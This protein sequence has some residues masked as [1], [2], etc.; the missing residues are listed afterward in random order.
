MH[1]R[2]HP[3]RRASTKEEG[4]FLGNLLRRSFDYNAEV[5]K[6]RWET[7]RGKGKNTST[8]HPGEENPPVYRGGKGEDPLNLTNRRGRGGA[9]KGPVTI[10]KK[11]D[12]IGPFPRRTAPGGEKEPKF[13]VVAKKGKTALKERRKARA[14]REERPWSIR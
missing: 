11:R 9:R 6:E 7:R 12:G 1:G 5:V 4:R 8:E 3:L 13:S 10:K 2:T 14:R